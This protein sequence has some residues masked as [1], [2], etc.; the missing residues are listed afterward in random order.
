M[1]PEIIALIALNCLILAFV[2]VGF[3]SILRILGKTTQETG[4]TLTSL[5]STME[6]IAPLVENIEGIAPEE[7]IFEKLL[8]NWMGNNLNLNDSQSAVVEIIPRNEKGHFKAN[9]L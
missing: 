9:D 6:I 4:S 7:T 5:A 8:K 1:N 2:I 3:R